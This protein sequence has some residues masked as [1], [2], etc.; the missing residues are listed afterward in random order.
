MDKNAAVKDAAKQEVK[1]WLKKS[2]A[3]GGNFYARMTMSDK[4]QENMR[5]FFDEQGNQVPFQR[6]VESFKDY[7]TTNG[8]HYSLRAYLSNGLYEKQDQESLAL[9]ALK[10]RD[11]SP[12]ILLRR[13]L[14]EVLTGCHHLTEKE[15]NALRDAAHDP[16]EIN[17]DK[18]VDSVPKAPNKFANIL[19]EKPDGAFSGVYSLSYDE[20]KKTAAEAVSELK[21][22]QSQLA[23]RQ[24]V[25]REDVKAG[26][27]LAEE[28]FFSGPTM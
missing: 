10:L 4:E 9:E 20:F 21:E 1:D 16:N 27:N 19:K 2:M 28:E 11:K 13:A 3:Y 5:H 7:V 22:E 8:M 12:H 24:K 6:G 25:H 23:N 26:R 17:K 14:V 15:F 18:S